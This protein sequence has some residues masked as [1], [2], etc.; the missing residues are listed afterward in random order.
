MTYSNTKRNDES[1]EFDY[2]C[3]DNFMKNLV[4]AKVLST[5][6][7]LGLIDFLIEKKSATFGFLQRELGIEAH[8]TYILLR[9]LLTNGVIEELNGNIKLTQQFIHALQYRDLLELKLETTEPAAS[10]LI[11]LFSDLVKAPQR[12]MQKSRFLGSFRY[13]QCYHY[14]EENY[15]TTKQWMRMTTVLTKYEALV[16][17]KYTDFGQYERMLDI[18]G[19]SG[20][21][22]LR[23]CKKYPN[24]Q[25]TVFDLP[26]VCQVGLEHIRSEPE[27][28]RISFIK[29]NALTDVLPTGF[30]LI[31]FK[32]M[33]HDWPENEA[34]HFIAR[35]S[36]SLVPES[37]LLIFER[38]P[39]E[40]GS[41][42]L[43][44]SMIP[45]LLFFRF[46]R[47][48]TI[49]AEHLKNLGYHDI[50]IQRI[51]L[52]TPFYLVKGRKR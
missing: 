36:Q 44:Y 22:V 8:G 33:L 50:Q 10:D 3:V 48:P 47:P 43:P 14:T 29:G 51:E 49:Y 6:F 25:A 24:I 17:M 1:K 42:T 5:A 39:L 32:S 18:G 11:D 4:D 45:A 21:F 7:E 27:A 2:L 13:D 15:E 52:E 23:I 37:T 12:F 16:C 46:F 9:L 38:G 41:A 35:A 26:L 34:K 28:D 31:T 19:N 20:E 40:I 30:N